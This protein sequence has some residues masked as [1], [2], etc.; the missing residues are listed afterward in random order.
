MSFELWFLDQIQTLR[1]PFWDKF[2]VVM[3]HLGDKGIML[4]LCALVLLGF[5]KTRR[6]GLT[7]LVAIGLGAIMTNLLL[8]NIVQRPRPFE[9]SMVDLLIKAPKDYAFPSGH[10]TASFAMAFVIIKAKETFSGPWL[11]LVAIGIACLI[12]CSRMYLYV[13]YPSDIIVAIGIAWLASRWSQ[14]WLEKLNKI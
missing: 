1:T 8:K 2:W 14:K 3:T 12:A 10:T 4:I 13:H 6:V 7:C 11:G 5:K 9:G